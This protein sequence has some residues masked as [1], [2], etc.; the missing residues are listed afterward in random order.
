M[1]FR[2]KNLIRRTKDDHCKSGKADMKSSWSEAANVYVDLIKKHFRNIERVLISEGPY[3][4]APDF[5]DHKTD[6]RKWIS[7]SL[8]GKVRNLKNFC[9]KYDLK[10][11]DRST[12]LS[13][14]PNQVG[15]T[16]HS[17]RM[18]QDESNL[19]CR[20]RHYKIYLKISYHL[21]AIKK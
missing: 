1:H 2:Y 13:L 10:D 20:Q 15:N 16:T 17:E 3:E 7:M 9:G 8:T 6:A 19:D 12:H 5:I 14:S 18:N 21:S 4:T 11:E